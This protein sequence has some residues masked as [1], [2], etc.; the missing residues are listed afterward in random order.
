MNIKSR[1]K[2]VAKS[3]AIAF[4]FTAIFV[5]CYYY[6][7]EDKISTYIN[8]INTTSVK[9]GNEEER[10][11]SYNIDSMKLLNYPKYGKKFAKLQIKSI[12]MNLPIYHGDSLK[13]LRYGIGHYA[14]SY[15]PGENGTIILAGHN[16][17][18]FF[19]KLD[20]IKKGDKVVIKANYATF[21]Y[22]VYNMKVVHESDLKAFKIQHDEERLIMYTCYPINRSIVGRKTKRYVVYA[23]KVGV[24]HE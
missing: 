10:E 22:E 9:K 18:G 3:L 7:V 12:D 21:E 20:K 13:I 17:N 1:I 23:K 24:I 14:G 15:F 2:T 19:N 5:L 11:T 8:L 16:T 4:F 6:F